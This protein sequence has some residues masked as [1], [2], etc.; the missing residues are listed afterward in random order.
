MLEMGE[1]KG[2]N[3]KNQQNIPSPKHPEEESI[4]TRVTS[5]FITAAPLF[6]SSG[7]TSSS[8]FEQQFE[9]NVHSKRPRF[10]TA[11]S[12]QWKLLPPTS[13][14]IHTQIS[15]LASE[16]SPSPTSHPTT[17]NQPSHPRSTVASSSDTAS[18]PPDHSPLQTVLASS[19]KDTT[20]LDQLG[21]INPVQGH[22][23]FRKGK[24]VSPVW[25]PNEMLWLARAWR[26]QHQGG[27]SD[28][29]FGS[30]SKT[31]HTDVNAQTR[32][33]TRA[34][35]DREVAEF[36]QRHGVNRDAKTAGTKWDNMLGEFRKVY[37]W[38]RGDEREQIGKSYFRLSPYER[39]LH[40]LPASF[41][42][43][44][45]E[46][47]SQF[48]GSRLRTP[49][50]KTGVSNIVVSGDECRTSLVRCL[51][52]SSSYKHEDLHLSLGLYILFTL[53]PFTQL[54]VKCFFVPPLISL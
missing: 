17:T 34:D 6:L 24:Y 7:A 18:S 49:P 8:P 4:E 21:E 54:H 43:E 12:S 27:E 53:F 32:G 10:S 38:E 47:L 3:S 42:E 51:P 20:N 44:V 2:D 46:E 22:H 35:K 45:Y 40:R 36:L 1:N 26:V 41:D 28:Q 5:P 52:A 9:L 39:K 48:M 50:T 25:K 29:L 11:T 15:I 33:K 14:Q 19:V 30:S 13:H 37:E 23:Q 16:S 31:E